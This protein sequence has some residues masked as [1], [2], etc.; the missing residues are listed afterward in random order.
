MDLLCGHSDTKWLMRA[1]ELGSHIPQLIIHNLDLCLSVACENLN[2]SSAS[3][4]RM[5][6]RAELV[7]PVRRIAV[8][9][10]SFRSRKNTSTLL[11]EVKEY[12][13]KCE[14]SD[15]G[16]GVDARFTLRYAVLTGEYMTIFQ[17]IAPV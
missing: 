14:V 8:G 3:R 7:G 6:G 11:A 4:C 13:A 12:V 16:A 2:Y 17:R 15:C 5:S 9:H 10:T 1:T